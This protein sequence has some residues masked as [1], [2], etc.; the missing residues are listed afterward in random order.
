M[1]ASRTNPFPAGTVVSESIAGLPNYRGQTYSA[2]KRL[3]DIFKENFPSSTTRVGATMGIRG[4]FGSGKTHLVFQLA[5]YFRTSMG[6]QGKAIYAKTDRADFLDLYTNHFARRFEEQDLKRLAAMHIA[7]LLRS[8][9]STRPTDIKAV[10]IRESLTEIALAGVESAV[11][12]NPEFVLSLVSDDLLPVA[13]LS[14]QLEDQFEKASQ[15]IGLDFFRAYSRIIDPSMSKMAIRW[16]KGEELSKSERQDLG[17]E[18][19][20]IRQPSHAKEAMRYFLRAHANA[21]IPIMFCVDEFERFAL[22]GTPE[23]RAATPGMLKDLSEMFTKTRHFFLLSGVDRCWNTM[24]KDFFDRIRGSDIVQMQLEPVEA[25]KLL[26][27]Y[28]DVVD[29]SLDDVFDPE[30]LPLLLDVSNRNVRRMLHVAHTAFLSSRQSPVSSADIMAGVDKALS[31]PD[32]INK[33]HDSI[34]AVAKRL[35]ISVQQGYAHAGVVPDFTLGPPDSPSVAINITSSVFRNDEIDRSRQL[36]AQVHQIQRDIPAIRTCSIIVGYSSDEVRRQLEQLTDA[37]FVYDEDTFENDFEEFLRA[38]PLLPTAAEARIKTQ[39]EVYARLEK[40]LDQLETARQ[41][42][43]DRLT[44]IVNKLQEEAGAGTEAERVERVGDKVL[45]IFASLRSVLKKEGEMVSGG[46]AYADLLRILDEQRDQL[47]SLQVLSPQLSDSD[48]VSEYRERLDKSEAETMSASGPPATAQLRQMV[49]SRWELLD[50]MEHLHRSGPPSKQNV[51]R[52]TAFMA[53]AIVG[54]FISVFAAIS[55]LQSYG[56]SLSQY[57]TASAQIRTT[58]SQIMADPAAP[59][60]RKLAS[61]ITAAWIQFQDSASD[62][63]RRSI[64]GNA[65]AK[66]RDAL[67]E[68]EPQLVSSIRGTFSGSA[69]ETAGNIVRWTTCCYGAEGTSHSSPGSPVINPALD[70]LWNLARDP[71]FLVGVY[72]F[73]AGAILYFLPQLRSVMRPRA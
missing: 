14:K 20:A 64:A 34:R 13:G 2:A 33:L 36:A 39:E 19:A 21:N 38:A 30:A 56:N 26:Q 42:E 28:C 25:K 44:Q 29:A 1:I 6:I 11:R 10:E 65:I 3:I 12:E 15:E 53:L 31:A 9:R 55:V 27:A 58:A 40:K 63:A 43:I 67:S 45:D 70:R 48:Y 72:F 37:L 22:R 32:R 17:L 52:R 4:P 46:F 71:L 57:Q 16:L 60:G 5:E 7:V 41:A 51:T 23:D 49:R 73:L 54:F 59:E 62:L 61:G 24:P 47:G 18:L 8:Q 50:K 35:R 66:Q 69:G 68:L